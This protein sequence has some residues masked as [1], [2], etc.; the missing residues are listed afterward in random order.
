VGYYAGSEGRR[1]S[2]DNPTQAAKS[3]SWE[4]LEMANIP[5][6]IETWQMTEPGKLVR[7]SLDVPELHGGE[8]LVEIA[9]CGICHTD[10]GYFYDGVPTVNK[11]PLTLGHEISGTVIAGDEAWLGKDVIIPAVMPCNDCPIC[12]DGRGNRCLAQKMP[13]NSMGIYGGFSS[14]IVV[15][16][17]NLCLIEDRKGI[18]LEQFAVIAD[19]ATSPYQATVKAGIKPGDL[20]VVVGASGGLGIYATQIL[21]ALG[22]KEVV[23]IERDPPKLETA[24]KYGATHAISTVGKSAREVRDEFRNYGKE[25]GLPN[26]GWKIFEWSGAGGGQE[27]A[28]ELLSFVG[29]LIIAGFG[30]QKNEYQLSRLMAFDADIRG[31]WGCLPENY[32]K[33]LDMVLNDKIQIEPFI[34]T[35]PMSTIEK[36]FEEAHQGTLTRRIVL[37]PDF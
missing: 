5:D 12:A 32:P 33:V 24:L 2:R 23:A 6:K 20:T 14:H 7:A 26:F 28:L 29:V 4:E 11:P 30:M 22:A 36:A 27:V 21:L 10:L 8:V 1:N 9:G 18:P 13:G 34:E 37:T 15:P 31:S 17:L 25:K 19:A 16:S 3:D 35:R